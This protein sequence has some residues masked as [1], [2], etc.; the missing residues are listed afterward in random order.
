MRPESERLLFRQYTMADLD[1][2]Y[3][4]ISDPETMQYYPKPYDREGCERW[5][6]WNLDNYESYGFG[7]WALVLKETGEFV[8]DCG[9]T[10]Q[11]IDG[12]LLPEIGYHIRKD[13]W[14]EGLGSEAAKAVRDWA[15]RHT[16]YAALYSYMNVRNLPSWKTAASVGMERVKAYLDDRTGEMYAYAIT[17]EKWE[18]MK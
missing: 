4:I 6:R 7:L 8:G 5:I 13:H 3:A 14:K 17:R 1:A 10:M 15:F 9:I 11:M 16:E 18:R 12:E 2:L